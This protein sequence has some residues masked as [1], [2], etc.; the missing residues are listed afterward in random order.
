MLRFRWTIFGSWREVK[1]RVQKLSR[2]WEVAQSKG[3]GERKNISK[4]QYH[5]RSLPMG[6]TAVLTR[7]FRRQQQ[8]SRC[9]LRWWFVDRCNFEEG[10]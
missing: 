10:G 4:A 5:E 7:K 6:V 1:F 8:V 2:S 3:C 9:I